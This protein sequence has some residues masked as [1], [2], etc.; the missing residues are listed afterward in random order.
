M[1]EL[2]EKL[3]KWVGF[4]KITAEGGWNWPDGKRMIHPPDFCN[5]LDACF[6]WLVPKLIEKDCDITIALGANGDIDI[7]IWTPLGERFEENNQFPDD[8][9]TSLLCKA[10]EK[11]LDA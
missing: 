2:N 6:K 4:T 10:I 9:L 8:T 3:A 7:Y 11:V 5:S 1:T